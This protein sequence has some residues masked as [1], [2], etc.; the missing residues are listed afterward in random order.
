[1]GLILAVGMVWNIVIVV[2][3][4]SGLEPTS[5]RFDGLNGTRLELH[6]S[7]PRS[8]LPTYRSIERLE[9]LI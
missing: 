3:V 8:L 7:K 1:M 2:G 4:V 6:D 5:G 9:S